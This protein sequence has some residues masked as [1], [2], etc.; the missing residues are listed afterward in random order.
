MRVGPS[1]G[2]AFVKNKA[3]RYL[4]ANRSV[5]LSVH[6]SSNIKFFQQIKTMGSQKESLVI[7]SP[8]KFHFFPTLLL[9]SGPVGDDDLHGTTGW[10]RAEHGLMPTL[11]H[12]QTTTKQIELESP[13]CS[14]FK[15]L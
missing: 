7:T 2:P 9:G 11:V 14:D 4:R 3:T 6:R 1:S 10:D 8:C 12:M 15:A 13:G 5:G